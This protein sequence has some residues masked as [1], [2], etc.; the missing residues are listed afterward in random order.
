MRSRPGVRRR[1]AP[2]QLRH[3][4][5]VELLHEGIPLPTDPAPARPRI[6]VNDRHLR[7]GI[8]PRSYPRNERSD[9]RAPARRDRQRGRVDEGGCSRTPATARCADGQQRRNARDWRGG[10]RVGVAGR[11]CLGEGSGV[12]AESSGSMRQLSGAG[13]AIGPRGFA[14]APSRKRVPRHDEAVQRSPSTPAATT[15]VRTEVGRERSLD[16]RGG[17]CGSGAT[18]RRDPLG[19]GPPDHRA[20]G[21]LMQ[22]AARSMP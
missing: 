12:A 18:R 22:S 5:A 14:S 15:S 9:A 6:P 4:H 21:R 19:P 10:G 13:A 3:A 8:S 7:A 20:G 17:E 1:L 11:T 16:V 2:H